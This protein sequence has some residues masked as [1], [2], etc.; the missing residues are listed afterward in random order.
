MMKNQKVVH[1]TT[2]HHPLD[3]RIYYKQCQSLQKAGYD[4]TLIAPNGEEVIGTSDIHVTSLQ[5]RNGRIK[6]MLL[7]TFEAYRKAKKLQADV[8]T[9]HDP[10]LLPV[11]W[12]LK[13]K[14]NVVI[15]DIHEDYETS[16]LQKEYLPKLVQKVLAKAYR[17]ME[18]FFSRRLELCLAEK[19]YQEK[20]ERGMCL[21]NYPILDQGAIQAERKTNETC[22]ELIYTGNLSETRGALTQARIPLFHPDVTVRFYGKCAKGLAEQM[23]VEAKGKQE[24]IIIEGIE[25]YVPKDEIDQA[26]L[27]KQWLAGIALFPYD[28]HY[29]RKE[30]TKFFEYMSHG[31]PILCSDFPVWKSFIDKHQ[32]GLAVDPHDQKAVYDAIEYLRT[33]REE[34]RKM[35]ENGRQ[36]V[37]NELNWEKEEEK[38]VAWYHKL[39]PSHQ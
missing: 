11:A 24:H 6:R 5:K 18:S 32:C 30:L 22:D 19:Y 20:Y 10:E 12:L 4:V 33:N 28:P 1:I 9:I 8:Y 29:M 35:G 38:L 3:P 36:A 31:L 13:K 21:L 25:R 7:S 14:S 15:Y 26:Y 37:V 16:I 39:I 17:L 2:V 27:E 23:Y 34:A